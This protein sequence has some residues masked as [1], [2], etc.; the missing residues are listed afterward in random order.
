[1]K[2]NDYFIGN[3]GNKEDLIAF[4]NKVISDYGQVDYIINNA[5]PLFKGIDE[6]SFEESNEALQVGVT[7]PFMLTKLL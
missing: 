5:K 3:V 2:K 4:T 1:M 6:C 7:G